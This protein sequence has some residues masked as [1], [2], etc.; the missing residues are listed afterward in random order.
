MIVSTSTNAH[1]CHDLHC[2]LA[3]VGQKV[4]VSSS[5]TDGNLHAPA[6]ASNGDAACSKKRKGIKGRH[7]RPTSCPARMTVSLQ[8]SQNSQIF[9]KRTTGGHGCGRR[10]VVVHLL[11][12]FL[13]PQP[14][15]HGPG[16]EAPHHTAGGGFHKDGRARR[17]LWNV[18][19][20]VAGDGV[21]KRTRGVK[22]LLAFP[23][24]ASR[25]GPP[26]NGYGSRMREKDEPM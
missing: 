23:R 8:H 18:R 20:L 19:V 1:A 25:R 13:H 14:Q 10:G 5:G 22:Q 24:R 6:G 15:Q 26:C 4:L 2:E 9:D 12:L 17:I 11:G 16:H 3:G 21:L 7:Y